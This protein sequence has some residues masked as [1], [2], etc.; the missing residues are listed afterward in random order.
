MEL[1]FYGRSG[2]RSG[3]ERAILC[4]LSAG[5]LEVELF[6]RYGRRIWL[7]GLRHLRSEALAD[8][9]VQQVLMLVI[10]SL[11]EDRLREPD[12]LGSFVLGSCRLMVRD[13]RRTEARRKELLETYGRAPDVTV[14]RPA[15]LDVERLRGCVDQLSARERTVVVLSFFA[16]ETGQEIAARLG[17]TLGN[18]RVLRHRA[19]DHL[20]ACMGVE[21][22]S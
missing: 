17:T 15:S 16:E 13:L 19:I 1:G 9:L 8:D 3:A 4:A 12:K 7:Y 10:K 2:M 5:D 18:V 11:R 22:A 14:E 20:K 6:R 21:A